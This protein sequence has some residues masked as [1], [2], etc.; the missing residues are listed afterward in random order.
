MTCYVT[1]PSKQKKKEKKKKGNKLDFL[2]WFPLSS[3]T[4]ITQCTYA[5][6]VS[7]YVAEAWWTSTD[8]LI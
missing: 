6:D 2:L 4:I 5:V 1:F 3:T 7:K 8:E